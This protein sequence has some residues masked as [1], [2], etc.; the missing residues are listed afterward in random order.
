M[1]CI[2]AC[3]NMWLPCGSNF[4]YHSRPPLA[5]FYIIYAADKCYPLYIVFCISYNI[6]CTLFIEY[7]IPNNVQYVLNHV[8]SILYMVYYILNIIEYTLR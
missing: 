2:L 7:F 6:Y 1:L 8:H 4:N 5:I 3:S